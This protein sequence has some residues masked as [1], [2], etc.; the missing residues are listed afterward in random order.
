MKPQAQRIV[1]L[2]KEN[3][4]RLTLSEILQT[5]LGREHSARFSELRDQGYQIDCIR[6]K[7]GGENVYVMTPP[8]STIVEPNGQIRMAL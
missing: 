6:G 5:S 4:Y 3:G 2:F 8:I 7:R 1:E